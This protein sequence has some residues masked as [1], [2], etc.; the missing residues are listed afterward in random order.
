MVNSSTGAPPVSSTGARVIAVG[1][2]VIALAALAT[3]L[4]LVVAGTRPD[5]GLGGVAAVPGL[6]LVVVS[7]VLAIAA[8]R[9][10]RDTSHDAR[11]AASGSRRIGVAE[12]VAGLLCAVA[13]GVALASYPQFTPWR[14]PTFWPALVLLALG[15]AALTS[16]TQQLRDVRDGGRTH[17]HA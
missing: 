5:A 7:L 4:V 3:G 12:V 2:V 17:S 9:V 16:S 14:S 11:R 10:L 1:H 6:A 8:A 13:A 15:V